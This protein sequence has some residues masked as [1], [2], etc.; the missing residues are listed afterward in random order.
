L[1]AI[2]VALSVA[3]EANNEVFLIDFDMRRPKMC[4]YLGTAPP[5]EINEFLEG[6]GRPEDVLFSVGIDN[7]TLAG[8]TTST[9]RASELLASQRVEELLEYIGRISDNPLI[10]IDIPPLLST[11]DSLIVAVKI[12]ACLLVLAEGKTRREGA[13]KALELLSEFDLAGIVLNR[14][15]AMQD[16]YYSA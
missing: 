10:I 14:S 4:K 15:K 16:D 12:D 7:L 3:T 1:T 6:R 9:F 8:T 11:D 13:A 2:N 5:L